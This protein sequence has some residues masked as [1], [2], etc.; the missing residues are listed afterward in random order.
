MKFS[1]KSIY[2]LFNNNSLH[3][4]NIAILVSSTITLLQFVHGFSAV[5]LPV[6]QCLEYLAYVMYL[7]WA[8]ALCLIVFLYPFSSIRHLI[9]PGWLVVS[10]FVFLF[11]LAIGFQ[12]LGWFLRILA[13]TSLAFFTLVTTEW[14]SRKMTFLKR[15]KIW[16]LINYFGLLIVLILISIRAPLRHALY[17]NEV[18]IFFPIIILNVAFVLYFAAKPMSVAKV[19]VIVSPFIILLCIWFVTPLHKIDNGTKRQN[20]ILISVDTLRSDHLGIYGNQVIKTP[21]IDSLANRGVVF[22]NA[23]T[24]VPLT[25]PSHSTM[26]TGL[27]PANHGVR[28]NLPIPFSN[29]ANPIPQILNTQGYKT[30]GFISGYTL[31]HDA[32]KMNECFQI[33]DDHL[34]VCTSIQ[35]LC[36]RHTFP[37]FLTLVLKKFGVKIQDRSFIFDRDAEKTISAAT[38]WLRGNAD[39]PFFLFIHLYDPHG[40]YTPPQPYN[41]MYDPDYTGTVDGDWY[42]VNIEECEKIIQNSNDLNHIKALYAGEI[43]YADS[44]LGKLFNEMGRL[45]L[46]SKTLVVFT[47]DHGES[48][49]EHNFYF[50]HDNKLY[51]PSLRIPLIFCFPDGM[52]KTKR[53]SQTVDLTDIFPTILDFLGIEIPRCDGRSL[54]PLLQGDPSEFSPRIAVSAIFA[55]GGSGSESLLALRS[56]EYKYIYTSSYW[57]HMS[58]FP[59]REELY[60]LGNDPGE[61]NN[62]IEEAPEIMKYFRPLAEEYIN[63]WFRNNKQENITVSDETLEKLRSLGYL[64]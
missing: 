15:L 32:S 62:I 44:Q 20:V 24:P 22:E 2:S 37:Y 38:Q 7:N 31:K 6:A 55:P 10:M 42:Q 63:M 23:L 45:G 33:Y 40:P 54:L 17:I 8:A 13:T 64:K 25:N 4:L 19:A 35:N 18:L 53:I 39:G 21:F 11:G 57:Y 29:N 46:W 28:A 3:T 30:A 5:K 36:M 12:D 43:S 48:L 1:E 60:A 9:W 52:A 49:T 59:S 16:T 58:L 27:M 61:K 14:I 50:A 51:E 41:T 26:L 34:G 47:S 56:T